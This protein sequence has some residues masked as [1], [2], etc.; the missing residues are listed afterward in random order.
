MRPKANRI[1]DALSF[2]ERQL[3][4]QLNISRRKTREL[5]IAFERDDEDV[6]G[7]QGGK[8][9]MELIA[10]DQL[11]KLIVVRWELLQRQRTVLQN[12]RKPNRF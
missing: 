11:D 1:L 6:F 2:S 3:A 5:L 8:E 4:W 9:L 10:A 7:I 12:L